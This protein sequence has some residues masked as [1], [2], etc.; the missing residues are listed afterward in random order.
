VPLF[1]RS[2][3]DVPPVPPLDKSVLAG[4]ETK[5]GERPLAHA[6]DTAGRAFV[7]TRLALYLPVGSTGRHRRVPWH[8]IQ[9]AEWDRD[10]GV[11]TLGEWAAAGEH[12]VTTRAAFSVADLLL[13]VLRERVTASVVLTRTAPVEGTDVFVTASIRRRSDDGK[14]LVQVSYPV[15]FD[16]ERPDV[17]TAAEQAAGQARDDVGL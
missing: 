6:W 11:L 10:T 5:R 7:A 2:R 1:S 17:V 16:P 14:L 12:R 8:L 4:L 3:P 9:A 13:T 15:G